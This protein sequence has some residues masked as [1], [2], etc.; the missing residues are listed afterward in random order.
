M[1][2]VAGYLSGMP[3]PLLRTLLPLY[4]LRLAL[5][6]ALARITHR[7]G[8][9]TAAAVCGLQLPTAGVLINVRLLLPKTCDSIVPKPHFLHV[10]ACAGGCGRFRHQHALPQRA[11]TAACV[12]CTLSS[13]QQ[14][15]AES[16]LISAMTIIRLILRRSRAVLVV[17]DGR[18][19]ERRRSKIPALLLHELFVRSTI[20]YRPARLRGS[21]LRDACGA[22]AAVDDG[23][24]S[25][26]SSP[27][28]WSGRASPTPPRMRMEPTPPAFRVPAG[29]SLLRGPRMEPTVETRGRAAPPSGPPC[30]PSA[31]R[32]AGR[33][34][35]AILTRRTIW[36]GGGGRSC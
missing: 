33:D 18:P 31:S 2:V 11:S 19:L 17:R 4:A 14:K 29:C 25:K 35:S 23:G 13:Q 20:A 6:P 34:S 1:G 27:N 10:F 15:E 8:W 9:S 24:L 22:P 30:S 28:M 16:C 26:V 32:G 5:L 21:Y 3:L 7:A 12:G 36:G